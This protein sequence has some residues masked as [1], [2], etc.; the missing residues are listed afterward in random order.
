MSFI[1]LHR[2]PL[3][4]TPSRSSDTQTFYTPPQEG[5]IYG[6][7]FTGSSVAASTIRPYQLRLEQESSQSH[8]DR[9]PIT[10]QETEALEVYNGF[11]EVFQSET[12]SLTAEKYTEI[13]KN[14][15][16][17]Y[18]NAICGGGSRIEENLPRFR[19][20]FEAEKNT[21][22]IL[23][24]MQL[25]RLSSLDEIDPFARYGEYLD[26]R[27]N[28]DKEFYEMT[29]VQRWL[30]E[31]APP[32]ATVETVSEYWP[33]TSKYL[34]IHHKNKTGSDQIV[35]ELDPD[36]SHRQSK[37]L[38]QSDEQHERELNR[39]IF[40]YLRRGQVKKANDLCV[41]NGQNWRAASL[42]GWGVFCVFPDEDQIEQ[43]RGNLARTLWEATC[44]QL[45]KEPNIDTYERAV[46]A[47]LCGDSKNIIPVCSTWEDF[48]WAYYV[49]LINRKEKKHLRWFPS[50]APAVEEELQM[51]RET[52]DL[53]IP[54]VFERAEGH[55]E[56][57]YPNSRNDIIHTIY[58]EVQK[59]TVLDQYEK[60]LPH[61][62]S[63]IL[64]I[65][66]LNIPESLIAEIIR[67]STHLLLYLCEICLLV[68]RPEYDA[69][70]EKYVDVLIALKKHDYLLLYLK[71]LPNERTIHLYAQ[72]LKGLGIISKEQ[73]KKY[74]D[75]VDSFAL[76]RENIIQTTVKMVFEE[77]IKKEPVAPP[78]SNVKLSSV[79]AK[80][81]TY[82]EYQISTLEWFSFLPMRKELLLN[83]L[84]QF[85]DLSK[86]LLVSGKLNGMKKIVD[87]LVDFTT[88]NYLLYSSDGKEPAVYEFLSYQCVVKFFISY[89]DWEGAWRQRSFISEMTAIEDWEEDIHAKTLK[90]K[91]SFQNLLSTTIAQKLDDNEKLKSIYS[92]LRCIY[93]PEIIFQY[94]KV[95]FQTR[96]IVEGNLKE[97]IHLADIVAFDDHQFYKELK[98]TNKLASFLKLIRESSRELLN[99]NEDVIE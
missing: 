30:Q 72:F 14:S 85:N 90:V 60:I 51:K 58:H 75:I 62:Y 43:P 4:N 70:I 39:S 26:L 64:Q 49:E 88:I 92:R 56:M 10:E 34:E 82:D 94:H 74:I 12:A 15:Y 11:A 50:E 93:F 22:M 37:H 77:A 2:N 95:L 41:N 57:R 23:Y 13:C 84:D 27:Q 55:I 63:Q 38:A 46:Y 52:V 71:R 28:I 19:E 42:A 21:W 79:N 80:L 18:T 96:Q 83:A 40:E 89:E 35:T 73:R 65:A 68:H 7:P 45:A 87:F 47:V 86:R 24:R 33:H 69:I 8:F 98:Q 78:I 1:S 32:F 59:Y 97:S 54:Q 66:N 48:L 67:F 81:N 99:K 25:G 61:I 16:D 76:N 17:I 3:L 36:A 5:G 31:T 29:V 6:T 44:Y 53:D 91:D 20:L 9:L